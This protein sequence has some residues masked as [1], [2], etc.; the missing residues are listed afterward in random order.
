MKSSK[1]RIRLCH[2]VEREPGA[3]AFAVLVPMRELVFT[4]ALDSLDETIGHR[5][6]ELRAELIDGLVEQAKIDRALIEQRFSVF[7]RLSRFPISKN[8]PSVFVQN[9]VR[10]NERIC[11]P[12][13]VK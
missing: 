11:R 7:P 9:P 1:T 6:K 4:Q 3:I 8:K 5:V 12:L 10:H 13:S 2:H